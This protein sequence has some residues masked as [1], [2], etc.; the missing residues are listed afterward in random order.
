NAVVGVFA[1]FDNRQIG[2]G[3]AFTHCA[4]KAERGIKIRRVEIVKEQPA[5]AALLVAMLQI[6]IIIAP[7]FVFRVNV[8]AKRQ[9]EVARS[10]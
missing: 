9:A 8:F 4:H 5:D 2:I 1:A 6:E 10:G 7:L 3:K